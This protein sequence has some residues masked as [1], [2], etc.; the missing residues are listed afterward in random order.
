MKK[1][2]VLA[3]SALVARLGLCAATTPAVAQAVNVSIGCGDVARL[4]AAVRQANTAGGTITLAKRCAYRFAD[5]F[6]N[7]RNAL[8]AITGNVTIVG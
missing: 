5:D 4:I 1:R 3:G 2:L 8:P 7:S 6:S